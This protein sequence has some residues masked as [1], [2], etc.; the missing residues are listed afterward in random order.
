[1]IT[2][3][4][5]TIHFTHQ[6]K[7]IVKYIQDN[8]EDILNYNAKELSKLIY[9]SSPTIIRF[10]QKLGFKGYQ[11][12]QLSYVK[13]YMLLKKN[14]TKSLNKESTIEDV[15]ITIPNI[16]SQVIDETK[17]MIQKSVYVRTI[18]YMLQAK[19]IDFYANDNNYSQVQSACLK[20]TSLGIRAQAYNTINQKYVDSLNPQE[21][22]SFVVSHTGRNKTIVDAAYE[23][24]KKR[25]RVIAIT[26]PLDPTLKLIC[27]ES[28]YIYSSTNESIKEMFSYG[29]SLNYILDILVMGVAIKKKNNSKTQ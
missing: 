5:K 11:D 6:E 8:P 29:I 17:H 28:L 10:T 13:E 1:M 21:V 7:T 24:R 20:L 12:F 18:N 16:Y 27:N 2:D 19:Q 3:L 22:L 4:F 15:I 23:L 9:V 14:Q 25:V 26:G